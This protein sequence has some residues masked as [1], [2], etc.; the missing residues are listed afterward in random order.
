MEK[1][2]LVRR[3]SKLDDPRTVKALFAVSGGLLGRV[4][5]VVRVAYEIAFRRNADFV[6]PGDLSEAVRRWA[7]PQ[8]LIAWNPFGQRDGE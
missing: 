3:A 2:G 6:E 8:A 1:A 7:V 5:N 4:S